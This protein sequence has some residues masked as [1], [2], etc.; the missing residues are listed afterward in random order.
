MP[1]ADPRAA[2]SA[3]PAVEPRAAGARAGRPLRPGLGPLIAI[4][5]AIAGK[6]SLLLALPPGYASA[7][8]PPAGIAVAFVLVLGGRALPWVF[9]GSFALNVWVSYVPGQP[10]TLAGV[11]A[12]LAIVLASR[13]AA[14][15]EPGVRF[16]RGS[17]TVGVSVGVS[18]YPDDGAS[19]SEI[20]RSAD[21]S[22]YRAKA[23]ARPVAG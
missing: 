16:G 4:L 3:G 15:L 2:L 20:I 17:L 1:T 9:L 21:S 22:M 18:C 5:Y 23:S 6:L 19:A 11:A 12:A 7:I 14:S 10:L 13:L 8:F